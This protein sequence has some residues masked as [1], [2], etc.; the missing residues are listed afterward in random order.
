[1]TPG[2]ITHA[3]VREL[4]GR[5]TPRDYLVIATLRRARIATA[6]QLERLWFT[7]AMPLS[8]ARATRRS[9]RHLVELRVLARVEFSSGGLGGGSRGNVFTLD[10]AGL[11]L[12]DQVGRGRSPKRP[13]PVSRIFLDH[14]LAITEWYVRLVEAERA[15]G[16]QLLDLQSGPHSSRRFTSYVG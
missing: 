1:M 3:H 11:R 15:G 16:P 6:R 10:V 4:A 14:A 5:L 13:Y 7:D 8:N 9:L 12:A 2:R